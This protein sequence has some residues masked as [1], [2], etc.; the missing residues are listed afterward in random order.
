MTSG[1]K[2]ATEPSVAVTLS[3]APLPEGRETTDH[4]K[5]SVCCG[6]CPAVPSAGVQA[7]V[8][9]ASVAWAARVTV[10]KP[11]FG[12]ELSAPVVPV[13]IAGALVPNPLVLKEKN[14]GALD[15]PAE[16]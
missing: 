2:V 4:W 12:D 9:S 3:A 14:A 15:T 8:L 5:A 13:V 1:L 10:S 11:T 6:S 7:V 16:L